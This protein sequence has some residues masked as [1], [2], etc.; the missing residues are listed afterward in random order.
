MM[1]LMFLAAALL[2][3]VGVNV[4]A[5]RPGDRDYYRRWGR[6]PLD[7]VRADLNRAERHLDY[8]PREE[9]RRFRHIREAINHFQSDWEQG[10]YDGRALDEAIGGLNGLVERSRLHERDRDIL[11]DDVHRMRELREHWERRDRD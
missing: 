10:H 8:L 11:A 4:E 5:Q 9:M 3:L 1:N 2:L 7:R 6:E